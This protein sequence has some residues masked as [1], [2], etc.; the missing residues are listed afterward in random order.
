MSRPEN[1]HVAPTLFRTTIPGVLVATSFSR[2]SAG[3][4]EL[5]DASRVAANAFIASDRKGVFMVPAFSW[6]ARPVR[7]RLREFFER[8]HK[9]S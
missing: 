2:P 8:N 5:L 4:C 1:A 6:V 9:V 7:H 3:L